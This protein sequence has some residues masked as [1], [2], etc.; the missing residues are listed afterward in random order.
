[1]NQDGAGLETMGTAMTDMGCSA[2]SVLLTMF[3]SSPEEAAS[4][5]NVSS[6]SPPSNF[7]FDYCEAFSI[8]R[9]VLPQILG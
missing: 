9:S 8:A 7:K 4:L 1:M 3:V 6:G 2:V 5:Y